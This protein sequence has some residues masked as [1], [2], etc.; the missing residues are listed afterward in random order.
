[1]LNWI[2]TAIALITICIY[3]QLIGSTFFLF[4]K[5]V[6]NRFAF[7]LIA[8]F[9][10]TWFL[11]WICGFPCELFS[12]S[13][14]FF[15]II[16][17]V[18]LIVIG[19]ICAL[20]QYKH[21]EFFKNIY[22]S[23]NRKEIIIKKFK[24]NFKE[25]WFV[26][27]LVLI[28]SVLSITNLQV[29]TLNNYSDDH[30]I[31]KV[32]HI[33]HS[34]Q[35]FNEDYTFG[36]YLHSFGRF[37]FA[38]QQ[39]QRMF[40]TYELVYSYLGTIF[41]IQ[42]VFF[43]RVT[44]VIHNYLICFAIFQ[45]VTSIFLKSEYSQYGLIPFCILFLP[46]GYLAK[47]NIPIKLRMWENWRFQTAMYM[48]G[49]VVRCCAFPSLLY[50]FYNYLQTRNKRSFLFLAIISATLFSFQT[51]AIS[52]II[53]FVPIMVCVLLCFYLWNK[54]NSQNTK[55]FM[56]YIGLSVEVVLII[57]I[58][59]GISDQLITNSNLNIN[60]SQNFV[61]HTPINNYVLN[62]ITDEYQLYYNNVFIFDFFAKNA[63]IPILSLFF[64]IKDKKARSILLLFFLMYMLFVLNKSGKLLGL[65]AIDA[66]G[67]A[68]C[69]ARVLTAI[70][71]IILVLFGVLVV[72][73]VQKIKCS[74]L[75]LPLVSL[76]L[77]IS[78]ICYFKINKKEILK[79]NENGDSVI[80]Q[81]YS[82]APIV[83]NSNMLAPVFYEVGN[84]FNSL[85]K[86]KY[87]MYS[88]NYFK[89]HNFNYQHIGFQL[90]SKNIQDCWNSDNYMGKKQDE[91]NLLRGVYDLLN[92]YMN[93]NPQSEYYHKYDS[94]K[95]T[96]DQSK[97]DYIF[98]TKK[99][100]KNDLRKHNWKVVLGSKSKGY[101]LLK[102]I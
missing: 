46:A 22:K 81:G 2:M 32:V 51:T 85:P 68:Y 53:I 26:Y 14:L 1:M 29:Y 41:N 60:A 96:I 10:V 91:N 77:A 90:S 52:Y 4:K 99:F 73:L 87:I 19:G 21:N 62:H 55:S 89:I 70:Q 12:T 37:S 72:Y 39:S 66:I 54:S 23:K 7:N 100:I 88:E 11:G 65:I 78:T 59:F 98:T 25:Y 28:F 84:Y 17:S 18:L 47:G 61:T 8:G 13:W 86:R 36:N 97:L 40:N 27:L 58:I 74:K 80:E 101:W 15:S 38:L 56:L 102:R 9:F 49:S 44:M 63:I 30:Y 48:G 92:L 93:K 16:F 83:N 3:Y 34:S 75:I 5:D 95:Q 64:L 24:D 31:A 43:C 57:L 76:A 35:L 69:I 50:Y 42:L 45:L 33:A 6:K 94:I 67:A 82:I 79:Y 20:I 71:M